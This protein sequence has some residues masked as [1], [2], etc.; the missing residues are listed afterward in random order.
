M[1]GL[2][3]DFVFYGQYWLVYHPVLSIV[4]NMLVNQLVL[5]VKEIMVGISPDSVCY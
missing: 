2:S 5:S 1:F 4:D 3:T